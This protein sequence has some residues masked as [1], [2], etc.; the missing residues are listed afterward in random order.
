[1][2]NNLETLGRLERRL[3]M[4]VPTETIEREVEQRLKKLSRSVRMHGFRPGK[5]PLKI[6]A[7]Q[8]GPQVRSEVIGDEVQKIFDAAVKENNLR[9]AGYPR[10]ERKEDIGDDKHIAFSAIF[11]VYPEVVL[12]DVS[13][14]KIERLALAIGDI[15]VDK[16]V[17]IMRKQ[18]VTYAA[19]DRAAQLG[20]RVTLDFTGAIDGA[21]FSGSKGSNVALVL[22]ENRMLPDFEANIAGLPAAQ[23]K[24]FSLNYPADYGVKEIAGKTA[25]FDITM[26]KVE[27]PRL[28]EVDA[29]F[30]KSLGVA[31][32]DLGK[33]RV[34]VRANVEREVK[35]RVESDLKQK[36]MQAL[37]DTTKLDLPKS[38]VDMETKRLV[39]SARADLESRG[40][41][42][43]QVPINP[44]VFEGQAQ[45]RVAL[46][47]VVGELVRAHN[48]AGTPEQI[49]ALVD[50]YA[51]TYEQP[52]EV[53]KWVYS[54]P[55]RLNEFE[56]LAVEANVIKW[57]LENVKVE[58]KA[59]TFDELMGKAG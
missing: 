37:L 21:E 18:R 23:S 51:Q 5:V 12:G 44:E 11:E 58:N 16:T 40:I 26:N 45:R 1:M 4:A 52:N 6:V 49:R 38:L 30:A 57:V 42:M 28:P 10:I 36:V 7:L 3:T 24:T 35:K 31:D 14:A 13:G 32:G 41:R 33:M 20:D 29:E 9:V 39:Q 27:A 19:A 54:Q 2:Q 48:L 50:D 22:G 55:E 47:I 46:G 34:E 53:V 25:V 43:E 15:D 8:Y 17:E 59:I 56:G